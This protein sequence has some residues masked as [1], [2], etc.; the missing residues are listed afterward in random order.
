MPA[1]GHDEREMGHGVDVAPVALQHGLVRRDRFLVP[2]FHQALPRRAQHPRQ[3]LG[4]DG[5]HRSARLALEEWPGIRAHEHGQA[6]LGR[7]HGLRRRGVAADSHAEP[8]TQGEHG[9]PGHG[10]RGRAP[11][12]WGWPD[13]FGR[14][15]S[16]RR[17]DRRSD[18]VE[19]GDDLGRAAFVSVAQRMVVVVGERA[20]LVVEVELGEGLIDG[21]LLLLEL[22][23]VV[24]AR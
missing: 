13:G 4:R 14:G 16:W 8:D 19:P 7:N 22:Q 24:E 23:P 5:F 3:H 1:H 2:P 11:R 6:A 9:Q 20:R 12:P 15:R 18:G 10:E 17:R 21:G